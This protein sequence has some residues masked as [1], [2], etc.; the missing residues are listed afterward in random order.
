MH[1]LSLFGGWMSDRLQMG[2]GSIS[3]GG[4]LSLLGY[5]LSGMYGGSFFSFFFIGWGYA[6]FKPAISSLLG[7]SYTLNRERGFSFSYLTSLLGNFFAAI[8]AGFM[9]HQW[10]FIALFWSG[11]ICFFLVFVASL[12]LPSNLFPSTMESP[13][14]ELPAL[15][16]K[17]AKRESKLLFFLLLSFSTLHYGT[18]HICHSLL[19]PHMQIHLDRIWR[20]KELPV[21][22]LASL[23]IPL[24]IVTTFYLPNIWRT[25]RRFLKMNRLSTMHKLSIGALSSTFAFFLFSLTTHPFLYSS[26]GKQSL[27]CF[28]P[29][30]FV[31][32]LFFLFSSVCVNATLWSTL[33]S[34]A[35]CQYKSFTMALIL[36]SI[37]IG[38][39]FS[40]LLFFF[41]RDLSIHHFFAQI[42]ILTSLLSP[43]ILYLAKK[44]CRATDLNRKALSL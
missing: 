33:F 18:H 7:H 41:T 6:L 1:L 15:F 13:S 19:I 36:L 37:C 43:P 40:S 9:R 17:K 14:L 28:F 2:K 24:Q 5:F 35:P 44:Q 12:A 16:L 21:T 20:G 11:M 4:G 38:S 8:L 22:W 27:Y 34:L 10:G 42:G 23:H 29:F 30:Y 31:S 32:L 25:F 39:L 3:L 26:S